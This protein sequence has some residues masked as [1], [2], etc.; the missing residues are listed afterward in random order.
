MD[1]S[2]I[3][4]LWIAFLVIE[5]IAGRKKK[6]VPP[7]NPAETSM[8]NTSFDIPNLANDPNFPGE[9]VTVFK[10]EFKPAEVREKISSQPKT[11]FQSEKNFRREDNAE[12]KS[13]LPLNLNA[14]SAM[15]AIILSEIFGKPKALQRK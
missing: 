12:S 8:S 13:N 15:N 5:N 4:I 1:F 14:D 6:K 2:I 11:E 3:I 9:D 7:P 10:D